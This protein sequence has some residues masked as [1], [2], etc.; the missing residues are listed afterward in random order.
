MQTIDDCMYIAVLLQKPINVVGI[1]I[2]FIMYVTDHNDVI[3]VNQCIYTYA[4][5]YMLSYC[6]YKQLTSHHIIYS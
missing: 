5:N 4:H 1:I 6:T 3:Y 2:I